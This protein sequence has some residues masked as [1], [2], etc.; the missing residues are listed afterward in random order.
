MSLQFLVNG[1][2]I[3]ILVK[4]RKISVITKWICMFI[5]N[6]HILSKINDKYARKPN[7]LNIKMAYFFVTVAY[8]VFPP[9]SFAWHATTDESRSKFE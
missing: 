8:V 2:Y 3:L 4:K 6:L 7:I 9:R 5:E 1:K